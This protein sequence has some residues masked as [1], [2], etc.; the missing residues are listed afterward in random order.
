VELAAELAVALELDVDALVEG[1]ADEVQR[2]PH[3][4]VLL[5]HRRGGGGG[6]WLITRREAC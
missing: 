1:E 3:G 6:A 4:A 2:L 5:G